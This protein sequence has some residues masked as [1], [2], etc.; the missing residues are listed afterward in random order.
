M[1]WWAAIGILI[2]FVV[3]IAVGCWV[4]DQIWRSKDWE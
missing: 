4:L 1:S 3:L 2:A